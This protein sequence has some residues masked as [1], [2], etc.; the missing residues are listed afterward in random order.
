L[1]TKGLVWC[2]FYTLSLVKMVSGKGVKKNLED[3]IKNVR[4]G[5]SITTGK[6]LKLKEKRKKKYGQGREAEAPPQGTGHS[7]RAKGKKKPKKKKEGKEWGKQKKKKKKKNSP[8]VLT[9]SPIN[10]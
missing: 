5:C 9:D 6:N 8:I 3:L 7:K 4:N 10:G 1:V 2:Q